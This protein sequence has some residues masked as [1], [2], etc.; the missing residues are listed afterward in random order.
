MQSLILQN[1]ATPEALMSLS[2]LF[3]TLLLPHHII[4]S[5]VPGVLFALPSSSLPIKARLSCSPSLFLLVLLQHFSSSPHSF[6]SLHSPSPSPS[7]RNLCFPL[8]R[9]LLAALNEGALGSKVL[10]TRKKTFPRGAGSTRLV[11]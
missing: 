9:V 2:V 7:S 11:T 3:L 10:S 6:P 1:P 4:S 5:F 8:H